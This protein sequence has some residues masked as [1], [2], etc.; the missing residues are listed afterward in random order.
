MHEL[1]PVSLSDSRIL[2][3]IDSSQWCQQILNNGF[4]TI[5]D[6]PHAHI[7]I[8][9]LHLLHI[10]TH[11]HCYSM[12]IHHKVTINRHYKAPFNLSSR[13]I[14]TNSLINNQSFCIYFCICSDTVI[15]H[16]PRPTTGS[17]LIFCIWWTLKTDRTLGCKLYLSKPSELHIHL[18]H[19]DLLPWSLSPVWDAGLHYPSFRRGE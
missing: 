14:L 5:V 19:I 10:H 1:L 11:R 7:F 9:S 8:Q 15:C 3:F 13:C 6:V 2:K 12:T 4:Q 18:F 17:V 16:S